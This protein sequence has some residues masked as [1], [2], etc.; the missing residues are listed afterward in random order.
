MPRRR[1]WPNTTLSNPTGGTLGSTT[2]TTVTIVDNDQ[3]FQFESA[4]YS[5]AEDAGAVLI[6]VLRGT[7]I[8]TP[9][10]PWTMPPAT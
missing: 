8:R 2:K 3:G 9:P 5:V 4:S 1:S 7:M 10:S 6:A